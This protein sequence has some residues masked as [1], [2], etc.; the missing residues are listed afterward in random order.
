MPQPINNL[1]RKELQKLGEKFKAIREKKKLTLEQVANKVGKD[2]QSIHRL[3]KGDFNPS[4]FHKEW[5]KQKRKEDKR[6]KNSNNDRSIVTWGGVSAANDV[7]IDGSTDY[8]SATGDYGDL[9]VEN[10]KGSLFAQKLDSGSDTE[11]EYSGSSEDIDVSYVTGHNTNKGSVMDKFKDYEQSRKLEDDLYEKRGFN[12]E[13]AWKSV[14]DNPMNISSQMDTI[15]GKDVK[16]IDGFK[17]KKHIDKDY[18]EA[19]KQLIYNDNDK[20]S[21]K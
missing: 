11:E 9:Y 14:M 17:K 4:T 7:G 5:E 12:D 13:H 18:A 8:I 1:Q 2:R 6:S 19:Y 15:V 16:Q 10:K 21:K 3:E 20:K